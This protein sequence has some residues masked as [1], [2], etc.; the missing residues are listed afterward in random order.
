MPL[1]GFPGVV[2]VPVVAFV[3]AVAGVPTVAGAAAV[4]GVRPDAIE[5]ADPGVPG[6]NGA[7]NYCETYN[8]FG[9]WDYGYRTAI[10]SCFWTYGISILDW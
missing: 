8:I 1:T 10:F 6:S 9:L 5:P 7:F 3:P 2:G 4:A